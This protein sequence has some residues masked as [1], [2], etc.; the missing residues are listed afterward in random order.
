[1]VSGGVCEWCIQA[2]EHLDSP[3]CFKPETLIASIYIVEK[4]SFIYHL[5]DNFIYHD[6]LV[7]NEIEITKIIIIH[8]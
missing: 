4:R 6:G 2:L 8:Q 7:V 3:S 1:M 5:R